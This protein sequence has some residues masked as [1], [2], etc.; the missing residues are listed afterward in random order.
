MSDN[1]YKVFYHIYVVCLYLFLE[2][3]GIESKNPKFVSLA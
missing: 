1:V 2:I 3:G